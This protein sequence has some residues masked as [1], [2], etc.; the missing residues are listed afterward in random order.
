VICRLGGWIPDISDQAN[1]TAA[2][3]FYKK[4][5]DSGEL[6]SGRK[7]IVDA[8]IASMYWFKQSAFHSATK[9]LLY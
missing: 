6:A 3:G 9:W 2:K 1:V 4:W 5:V 8:K 7:V